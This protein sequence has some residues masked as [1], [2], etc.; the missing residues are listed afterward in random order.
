MARQV[1]YA[2]SAAADKAL[3][4]AYRRHALVGGVGVGCFLLEDAA[5]E[6]GHSFVHSL[7]HLHACY[8]VASTNTLMHRRETQHTAAVCSSS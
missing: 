1:A 2:R 4:R 7:W 5:I 3:R 8:A 6:R